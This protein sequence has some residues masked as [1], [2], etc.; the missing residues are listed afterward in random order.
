VPSALPSIMNGMRIGMGVTW[1]VLIAAEI[2]PG[3]R[4][5]I[6]YM[7]CTACKTSDYQYSFAAVLVIAL[8][9]FMIDRLLDR[10]ERGVSHW[11]SRER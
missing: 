2:F 7:L 3:T 8:T 10:L 6:G 4:S 9:G 5:G 11:Q 1:L